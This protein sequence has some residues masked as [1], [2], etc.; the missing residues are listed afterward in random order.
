MNEKGG[1]A[2]ANELGHD[3]AKIVLTDVSNT[4]SVAKSVRG[5]LLWVK[6]TGKAVGGV[7]AAA[8]VGHPAKII[9]RHG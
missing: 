2:L 4:A 8:G 3:R 6:Q 1:Q 9:E 7:V 5:T